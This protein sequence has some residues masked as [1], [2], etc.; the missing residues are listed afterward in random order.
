MKKHTLYIRCV[1]PIQSCQKL[2]YLFVVLHLCTF[3]QC[4][5]SKSVVQSDAG[6][7]IESGQDKSPTL[8]ISCLLPR[9]PLHVAANLKTTPPPHHMCLHKSEKS[10]TLHILSGDV[11]GRQSVSKRAASPLCAALPFASNCTAAWFAVLCTVCCVFP[12]CAL[13]AP[14]IETQLSNC[15]L[16]PR[17][18]STFCDENA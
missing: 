14:A 15:S 11:I 7:Y 8:H 10:P 17:T 1:R 16:S 6:P 5:Q 4:W 9:P 3:V 13:R 2:L 18:C 12:R